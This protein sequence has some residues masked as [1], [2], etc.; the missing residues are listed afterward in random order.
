MTIKACYYI[1]VSGVDQIERDGFPRQIDVCVARAI[2]HGLTQDELL[3]FRE[4]GVS[5]TH[6]LDDRPELANLLLYL[7]SNPDVKTVYV[8]DARRLARDLMVQ[9]LALAEFRKLNVQ[10][11]GAESDI[12]LT[13]NDDD[14]TKK[15][16]RQ[17][18]GAMSEWDKS[19]TVIKLRKA[20]QRIKL[21]DG[22]CEGQKPFGGHPGKPDEVL[23]VE[24]IR[25]LRLAGLGFEKIAQVITQEGHSTRSGE[26]W[27]RG[28]IYK[29]CQNQLSKTPV[30]FS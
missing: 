3:E 4:E 24:R 11:I 17:V 8:E 12:D 15:L 16:I 26:P 27:N 19:T 1:R 7:Q 5:G 6:A 14:P 28:T 18:L 29:L 20:R 10:V 22:R 9:E 21:T 13:V 23:T 25:E 30:K 2:K